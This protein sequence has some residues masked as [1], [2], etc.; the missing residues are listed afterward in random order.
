MVESEQPIYRQIASA[1]E[2]DIA[3]GKLKEGDKL[4]SERAMAERLGVSRMTARQALQNLTSRG[5]LVTRTGQGTFVGRPLIQQKLAKLTGF[6][7]EMELQGRKSSS[8]VVASD[9]AH[10]DAQCAAALSI[11]TGDEV[12]RLVRVR[13][14]DDKPVAIET[15]EI[16]AEIAP[17]LLFMA[18]F[19]QQSLYTILRRNFDINPASAEQTLEASLA[20]P[21][22]CRTLDV[23]EGAAVLKLTRLTFDSRGVPFEFV[24]SIYRGDSFV[25]KVDLTLGASQI[26]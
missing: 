20:S 21:S 7:E 1:L 15:T 5:I 13:L 25:M 16:P 26:Q 6:T 19:A 4:P 2:M 11:P 17:G 24:R 9:V 23:A 3:S 14:A 18:D 22:H 10:A 12:L 8:I